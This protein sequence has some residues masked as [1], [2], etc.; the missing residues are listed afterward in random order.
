MREMADGAR[1]LRRFHDVPGARA[2][3]HVE[4]VSVNFFGLDRFV[5]LH[6]YDERLTHAGIR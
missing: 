3:I 6:S 2:E 4:H 1:D 5:P